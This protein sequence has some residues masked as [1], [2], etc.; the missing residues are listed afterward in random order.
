MAF[1]AGR[2][3]DLNLFSMPPS[4]SQHSRVCW[5]VRPLKARRTL[6][7]PVRAQGEVQG[8]AS[9]LGKGNVRMRRVCPSPGR[10]VRKQ[11]A[12]SLNKVRNRGPR[13]MWGQEVP[14]QV[15]G[16]LKSKG[17]SAEFF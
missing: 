1:F 5:G 3:D 2:R 14:R 7:L 4:F 17:L 6:R 10:A 15:A 9:Y 11:R 13:A 8:T 12:V 16:I